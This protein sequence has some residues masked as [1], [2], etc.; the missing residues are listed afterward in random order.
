MPTGRNFKRCVCAHHFDCPQTKPV[1]GIP[2]DCTSHFSF[3]PVEVRK[4]SKCCRSASPQTSAMEVPAVGSRQRQLRT[5]MDALSRR[6]AGQRR[7]ATQQWIE[8]S[9]MSSKHHSAAPQAAGCQHLDSSEDVRRRKTAAT[10]N[11][12][13]NWPSGQKESCAALTAPL[14]STVAQ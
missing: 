4:G 7:S 9:V 14:R 10:A 13:F 12:G 1:G 5:P 2:F 8:Q 3:L 6:T 11:G